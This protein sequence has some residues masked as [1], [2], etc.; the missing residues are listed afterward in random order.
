MTDGADNVPQRAGGLLLA[1]LD[2]SNPLGFMAAMGAFRL[3]ALTHGRIRMAWRISDGTWH[4]TVL[5]IDVPEAE[6]G[7]ELYVSL[8]E[9]DKSV[10]SLDKKLP[11]P[12]SRLREE[13]RCAASAAS[14][15]NRER[16][17]TVAALGV[18]VYCD[19]EGNFKDTAFRMVRAGDSAGQGFLA[20]GKRILES[21]TAQQL[22]RAA[23]EVWR[24][25]DAQ[26]ALRWDPAEDRGYALQWRDPS[27]VGA[28]SVKGGN[29]L[30][31]AA[32]PLF[33]TAPVK[34]EA[35]TTGFGLKQSKN[36]S[37][38]WPI[39]ERALSL[40]T[41]RSVLGL[42]ALQRAQPRT[43]ELACR[44]IVAAYR[45]DRIMTSTYYSNFTPAQRVV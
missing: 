14:A 13:A 35:E 29:C 11:F 31:L 17:D 8:G 33:P 21:T 28:L 9:L 43:A 12:A 42:P 1:G 4:P 5:G 40:D 16:A 26:C 15:Q 2:G 34:G 39:W 3:L 44:G 23:T 6:I 36:S 20:Y 45:C 10:W 27:K 30:A 19:D 25:E 18:E 22:Q 41:V 37:F 7:T 32:M 24:H 38:T